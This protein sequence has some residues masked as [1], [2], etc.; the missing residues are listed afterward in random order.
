M[1]R[2][3]NSTGATGYFRNMR[4]FIAQWIGSQRARQLNGNFPPLLSKRLRL[5][6]LDPSYV[7]VAQP[8]TLR[9]LSETCR[10][11]AHTDVCATDLGDE[12]VAAG[13][14][15]YCANGEMIDEL[16]IKRANG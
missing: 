8:E 2:S 10:N 11:C 3:I 5:L 1:W 16:V 9:R 6:G 13:M 7:T 15:T 4:D 14:D 12:N